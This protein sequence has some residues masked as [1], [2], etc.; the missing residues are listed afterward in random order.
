MKLSKQGE[1][2]LRS[3]INTGITAEK[4]L[5]LVRVTELATEESVTQIERSEQPRLPASRD[6]IAAR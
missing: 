6:E 2:A 5:P 4:S 3:L 1:Y